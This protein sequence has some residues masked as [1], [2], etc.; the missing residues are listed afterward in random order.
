MAE[1]NKQ[2]EEKVWLG[3]EWRTP[4]EAEEFMGIAA[5]MVSDAYSTWAKTAKYNTEK[6]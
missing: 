4:S 3:H 5:G 1:K 2:L 6:H